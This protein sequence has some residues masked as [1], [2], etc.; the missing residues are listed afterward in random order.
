MRTLIRELIETVLLALLI[1]VALE[2]SIQN[3]RVEG[4]SMRSTLIEGQHLIVNK[5]VYLRFDPGDLSS[6]VPFA[7]AASDEASD[8]I[9]VFRAPKHGDILIFRFPADPSRDFVKRVIGVP[10]DEIEI[11]RGQV[12]RNGVE[13]DEP[14]ITRPDRRTYDPIEVPEGSYYVLGDNRRTSNDS[15]NWGM[16]PVDNVIARAL[17]SYWPFDEI[18]V[19]Q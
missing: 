8:P 4:S 17:F 7:H 18:G 13:I 16:V 1:F 12:I 5:L 19:L 14:Y 10:G 3:F 15:R 11:E 6:V 2:F 9:F